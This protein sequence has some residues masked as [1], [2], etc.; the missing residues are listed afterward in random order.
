[1]GRPSRR[2]GMACSMGPPG[3]PPV[4]E[5]IDPILARSVILAIDHGEL[6][7]GL[8]VKP[9]GQS[10]AM[11]MGVI[12]GRPESEAMEALRAIVRERRVGVVVLGLPRHAGSDQERRVKAFARKLRRGISGVRWTFVDETLTSRE[13]LERLRD[14]G[15]RSRKRVT[16]D[17]AA[18]LI[19]ESYLQ[20]QRRSRGRTD[21]LPED[22]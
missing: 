3:D 1:V 11:P 21:S 18:M 8:A 16:D 14:A 13:A 2:L 5:R 19:L 7:I 9:A 6:R 10:F 12:P 20:S 4:D 17:V 15:F 22:G